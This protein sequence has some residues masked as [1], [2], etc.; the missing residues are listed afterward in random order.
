M[1]FLN[2]IPFLLAI[3]SDTRSMVSSHRLEPNGSFAL[4]LTLTLTLTETIRGEMFL[5]FFFPFPFFL[6]FPLREMTN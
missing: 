6:F 1:H 3:L 4:T 5:S 2:L